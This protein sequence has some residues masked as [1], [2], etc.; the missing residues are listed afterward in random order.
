VW[1]TS[2]TPGVQILYLFYIYKVKKPGGGGGNR[3]HVR[4]HYIQVSTC[5]SCLLSF[6]IRNAGKRAFLIPISLFLAW[7][8]GEMLQASLLTD[9][10]FRTQAILKER[11]AFY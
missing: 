6:G 2:T 10:T 11:A 9:A 8:T 5:L 4:K 1:L 3:T 7:S